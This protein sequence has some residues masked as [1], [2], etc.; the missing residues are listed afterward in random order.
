MASRP[1]PAIPTL[2][3]HRVRA[4]ESFWS[5]AE[6]VILAEH[7]AADEATVSNYWLRLLRSNADR[8]PVSGE[9]DL[10]YA[11]VELRLPPV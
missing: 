1:S 9:P 7:P 11:G 4:G 6:D 5:I 10:L 2:R 3:E 8:L